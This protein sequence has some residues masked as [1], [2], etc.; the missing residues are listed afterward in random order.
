MNYLFP[1][2]DKWECSVCFP[3]LPGPLWD[4]HCV[5]LTLASRDNNATFISGIILIQLHEGQ[6]GEQSYAEKY[7]PLL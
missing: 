5:S 2:C 1:P 3:E 7:M 6:M 4:Q